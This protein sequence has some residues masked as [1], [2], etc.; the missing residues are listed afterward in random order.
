MQR[1]GARLSAIVHTVKGR[2][3]YRGLVDAEGLYLHL[4]YGPE[5]IPKVDSTLRFECIE[6]CPY[7]HLGIL[8]SSIPKVEF[9][10]MLPYGPFGDWCTNDP[11]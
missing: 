4:R 1:D 11:T 5:A 7:L 6:W 10:L 2:Y 9:Y 3:H 8:N